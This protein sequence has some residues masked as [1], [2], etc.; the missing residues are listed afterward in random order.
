MFSVKFNGIFL[1]N[2]IAVVSDIFFFIFWG[3]YHSEFALLPSSDNC[4]CV[5]HFLLLLF[6]SLPHFSQVVVHSRPP[7]LLKKRINIWV[8][9]ARSAYGF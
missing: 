6:S 3:T 1:S 2:Y 8:L 5:T 7:I 4:H 9:A